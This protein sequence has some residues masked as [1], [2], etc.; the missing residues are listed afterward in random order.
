MKHSNRYSP[1]LRERAVRLV[2]NPGVGHETQ[3]A[4]IVSTSSKAGCSAETLHKWMRQAERDQ[5]RRP[6]GLRARNVTGTSDGAGTAPAPEAAMASTRA[7]P[8]A[9][10]R[11]GVL[12]PMLRHPR[13]PPPPWRLRGE[14]PPYARK[15]TACQPSTTGRQGT[16]EGRTNS[17]PTDPGREA[18]GRRGR[19]AG[20]RACQHR[21]P[22]R[23]G[24]GRARCGDRASQ[25]LPAA[26]LHPAR[27]RSPI[28]GAGLQEAVAIRASIAPSRCAVQLRV[29]TAHGACESATVTEVLWNPIPRSIAKCAGSARW[30]RAKE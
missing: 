28:D 26:R 6:G 27:I 3:W 1:E 16:I 14:P 8:P 21:A 9:P 13:A 22:R 10:T 15:T 2:L 30:C 19:A 4:A 18:P 29:V 20:R 23:P 25:P 11:P 24:L 17:L 12:G 7:S 5:S